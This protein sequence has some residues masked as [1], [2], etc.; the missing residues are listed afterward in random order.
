MDGYG[1]LSGTGLANS[2]TGGGLFADAG[3]EATA[4]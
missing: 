2:S 3:L 4:R 1:M